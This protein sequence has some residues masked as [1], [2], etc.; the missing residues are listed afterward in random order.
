MANCEG[1]DSTDVILSGLLQSRLPTWQLNEQAT[2]NG[3][4]QRNANEDFKL[5]H[6]STH[7]Y[8]EY[9][10]RTNPFLK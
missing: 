6:A 5:F 1:G 9:H 7:S 8:T 4:D 2:H 3:A 10:R